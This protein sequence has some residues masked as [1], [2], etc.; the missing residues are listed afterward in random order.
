MKMEARIPV[1]RSIMLVLGLLVCLFILGMWLM[2]SLNLEFA[3]KAMAEQRQ[4]QIADT[5]YAN[6]ERIN[7]HHYLMEQNTGELARLG[8][9]YK[10]QMDITGGQN[11]A[12]F[13]QALGRV[14]DDLNGTYG[15]GIW[16]EPDGYVAGPFAVYGYLQGGAMQI[17]S[18]RSDYLTRDWYQQIVPPADQQSGTQD[19]RFH[20]TPAYF[21]SN[22]EQV[23]ISLSTPIMD[24]QQNVIGLAS[25]DWAAEDVIKLV[26]RAEVTPGAFSFLIDSENRTLSSLAQ[27]ED[28]ELAKRLMEA[29]TNSHLHDRPSQT[30]SLDIVSARQ[31]VS[32]MQT[33]A[34]TVD[35]ET[36][37]LFFSRT[38]ADMVFG[39]GV[40]QTEIDAVLAPMRASNLRIVL[41]IGSVFLL[42]AGLILYIIA[43]TL[44]QL[45]NLYTDSLTRM[46]NREKLLVDLRKT[47]SAALILLN[48]DAFK[49]I[50]DFYGHE[51][52]DHVIIQLAERM[53][54]FLYTQ[55]AW[56]TCNLYSMPGDEMA[57]VV[58]GHHTPASLPSRLDE[59]LNYVSLLNISWH[60]QDIPLHASLG[61]ATTV[62]P[63]NTRL[64][65]EQLLP[66]ASMAL[67]LARLNQSNYFIYDPANR[68]REAYE[69]NLIWA[70][71]LKLALEEG[72]IVPFFQPIMD[73]KTGKIGKFECLA[74]M[75]DANGQPVSPERFLSIA[76]KIRLYRYITRTM[77]EQCFKRFA[78]SRYEFSL[79]LSCE[80]L[81]DTELTDF[82]IEKLQGSELANRVIFEILETEGIENYAQVRD[83]IDKAKALGCRIAIDDFGTGYSNFEHLLRLN[84]DLIKIDGSLIRNLDHNEDA[85]TLTRG[86]VR[87][88]AELGIHTVAEF[89]HS[90]EVLKQVRELGI[91]FAQGACVGMPASALITEVELL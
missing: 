90:P 50:N 39:I 44:R 42:L 32:P 82:I 19:A 62:Q 13:E 43:G 46:P 14:L 77:V 38:A 36:Y 58:P 34:L 27:T 12:E 9:L 28:V 59:L 78:S 65:G 17:V 79:N 64:N 5:F 56:R 91:D 8:Q 61:A 66:S 73:V 68:V 40:P 63:D 29:V 86:I 83:F 75:L 76:K 67:K 6:L 70:N 25:T 33:M 53:Q 89:V 18:D 4:R 69:Q 51:C 72:R 30:L 11:I 45:S 88:A 74:R 49:Q 1:K 81:L 21:K 26:S 80:D 87:F 16:F 55:P 22:I 41:L 3:E 20:W 23:V 60:D 7:G 84:I 37:A 57:I 85:L 52:G 2:S 31:L 10:R 24:N 15:G 54:Q 71:S 48:I 35:G 47:D